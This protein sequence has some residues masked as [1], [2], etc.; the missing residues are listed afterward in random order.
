[1]RN[2]LG[3]KG[4]G[5]AEMTRA[6][7][8][9]PAGFTISTTACLEYFSNDRMLPNGLDEQIDGALANVELATGKRFGGQS[10]PLLVSVRSGARTSM[11]GMMDTVLNL[12]LNATTLHGLIARTGDDRF[13]WD[14]YRRFI[15]GFGSIVLGVDSRSF[16]EVIT[17]YKTNRGASL[18]TDLVA[19]DWKQVADEFHRLIQTET[20]ST[21]PE[22]PR[23]QLDQA[24]RAVFDSWYGRRAIDYRKVHGLPDDWGT[25]VNIQTMVFG[26]MGE[27]SGT[28]VAF[29]RNPSNG[30]RQIFGEYLM[31][32]Q[33]E[34]VVAG[35]R[36][37]EP[38]TRLRT[39]MPE[40]FA[41]FED[42][43]GNLERHYRD[44]Q[45]MEFTIERGSLYMLQ[46]R[47]GKRSPLAAVN[48]AVDMVHEGLI[49]KTEAV[50][51]IAP[52][53]VGAVLFP[54]VDPSHVYSPVATG[55]NA[56]PGA[57]H[58][59]VTFTADDAVLLAGQG[60]SVVL[61]R[62]ETSPDD[63]HGMVAS[64]A[65]LTTRGGATSHAAIVA[66]QLG[67]PAI[68]GSADLKINLA[69]QQCSLNGTTIQA[70][71]TITI[72]GTSGHVILGEAPL[73]P[74][75]MT[76][77]LKELLS[78]ADDIRRLGV[79]ANADT[80]EEAA[81]ARLHGAEGIG[82]C[83]T[84]HMFREEERLP[85][86]HNL[87]LA[88]TTGERQRALDK[89][90]PIQRS[91][92]R[93]ILRAMDGLPVV[94]RLLDPPLHEFLPDRRELESER[95]A[96]TANDPGAGTQTARLTDID[97]TLQR[98]EDLHEANPML[99][100]RGSRLGIQHPEIYDMQVRA[101]LEASAELKAEGLQPRPKIMIPLISHAN[102]LNFIS[103]RLHQLSSNLDTARGGA[104]H[105]EFG[106]MIEVPRACST[107]GK[108][109]EISDF[110]SFGTN[111]LTQT[112]FGISRD[113]A[114]RSFLLDY[115]QS[116]I[117]P[118]NPFQVLDREGV[119]T[120]IRFG[121]DQARETNPNI[122][123]GICGE[124]GGDPESIMFCE[125]IGLDYVSA[126]PF[127]VPVARMAAAHARLTTIEMDH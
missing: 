25:A 65:I 3:G 81:Q 110:F 86:V 38:I 57:A 123:M 2:L 16:E 24:I 125:E 90:L 114:E 51:R 15:Q 116:G 75:S 52:E 83:R 22:D 4:A 8:P 80:P 70:G 39:A 117:L 97:R 87:I 82:L 98:L 107:A 31:N 84:E 27:T 100:L 96:L 93:G 23:R 105:Y 36:T 53:Q 67:K 47:V 28:G 55:L 41:E 76:P 115:V 113:D 72:D 30:Q 6:G 62:P 61:V 50:Q 60:N 1:M 5:V 77:A 40:S 78:W 43:A 66:R 58:G 56:S 12:G 32:A 126:S 46:T 64:V 18:D 54:R 112:T 104:V 9:V 44:M 37:P 102:E 124:H 26:N 21:F 120:I 33:G 101:I 35:V 109:A 88:T 11:P 14:A 10:N 79:W 68:V 42:Y 85:I 49:E 103:Q 48:I 34:D 111:D 63:F 121:V 45:D 69:A 7:M 122:E 29:T 59:L 91:D 71:D 19:S 106:T 74:G 92:F 20:S 94:I 89:L 108:L 13:G 17:A 119:G 118:K 99:G 95:T 73:V 127:R